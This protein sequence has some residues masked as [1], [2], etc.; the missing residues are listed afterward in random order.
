M[1]IE[2]HGFAGIVFEKV[3]EKVPAPTATWRAPGGSSFRQE[4]ALYLFNLLSG[5]LQKK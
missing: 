2:E 5:S 4:G 1:C 3:V